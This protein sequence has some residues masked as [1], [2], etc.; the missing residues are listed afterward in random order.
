VSLIALS[1]LIFWSYDGDKINAYRILV[2]KPVKN[3]LFVRSRQMEDNIKMDLREMGSEDRKWLKLVYNGGTCYQCNLYY[4]EFSL[5]CVSGW[6]EEAVSMN[7]IHY[8]H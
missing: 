1:C 5:S 3:I 2:G 8:S 7:A 4:Q 6:N